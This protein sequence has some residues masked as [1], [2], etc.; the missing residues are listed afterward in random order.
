M[1]YS[2]SLGSDFW[3]TLCALTETVMCAYATP[4]LIEVNTLVSKSYKTEENNYEENHESKRPRKEYSS[5]PV[6]GGGKVKI[7][8]AGG[9][10]RAMTL[11][12]IEMA[13]EMISSLIRTC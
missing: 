3:K 12:A 9:S 10:I 1:Y 4:G 8:Y 5:T 6:E 11:R 13:Q 2:Y 7:F